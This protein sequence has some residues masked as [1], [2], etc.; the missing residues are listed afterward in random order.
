MVHPQP[1]SQRAGPPLHPLEPRAHAGVPLFQGT[2]AAHGDGGRRFTAGRPRSCGGRW[3]SSAREAHAADRWAAAR[4]MAKQRHRGDRRAHH[5]LDHV[6]RAL[7]SRVAREPRS[8]LCE[9]YQGPLPAAFCHGASST[10]SRWL[11]I[12]R[13]LSRTRSAACGSIRSTCRSPT[14]RRVRGSGRSHAC[15]RITEDAGQAMA[16]FRSAGKGGA[17]SP[18]VRLR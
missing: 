1:Q 12:T 18:Q 7:V 13:P 2:A 8:G 15:E 16:A 4:G 3:G 6:V 17:A 14:G 9:R 11:S 10:T 5:H